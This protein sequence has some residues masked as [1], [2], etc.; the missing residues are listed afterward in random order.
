MHNFEFKL[1]SVPDMK[2]TTKDIIN[3]RS[4]PRGEV[5]IRGPSV[6]RGYFRREKDTKATID[7]RGW[8]HTGDIAMLLPDG[9][10]KVVDRKKNLF[11]LA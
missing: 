2:Y 6:T 10:L 4:V 7:N 1:D 5:C 8:L 9:A 3:G 11:K